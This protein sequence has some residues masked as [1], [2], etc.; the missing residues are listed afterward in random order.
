MFKSVEMKF[1]DFIFNRQIWFLGEE[2]N[3]LFILKNLIYNCLCLKKY[4]DKNG[5]EIEGK[6]IQGLFNLGIYFM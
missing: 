4:R 3:Y 2:R 1:E 5:L 6:V